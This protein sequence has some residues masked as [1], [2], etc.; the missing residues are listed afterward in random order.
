MNA[1]DVVNTINKNHIQKVNENTFKCIICKIKIC[2]EPQVVAHLQGTKHKKA[3][4]KL[5]HV[6]VIKVDTRGA[7][8]GNE[9]AQ[10]NVLFLPKVSLTFICLFVTMNICV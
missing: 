9:Y 5:E 3:I 1:I 10:P 6:S 8:H 2:G 4:D 7:S